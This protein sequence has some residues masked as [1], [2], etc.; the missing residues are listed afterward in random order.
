MLNGEI[1]RGAF[2]AAG[3]FGHTIVAPGGPLCQCG[4]S[5]CLET[6]AS[7]PALRARASSLLG[8]SI[9]S[10]ELVTLAGAGEPSVVRVLQEGGRHFG[11]AL[12]C[13]RTGQ[14][15]RAIAHIKLAIA[16]RP[17]V[18]HYERALARLTG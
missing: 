17:G 1:Y 11:L 15:A 3:E 6:F 14:R 16:M 2:G 9:T 10:Q 4:R 12:A 8:R 7:E 5:G 13:E 18:R